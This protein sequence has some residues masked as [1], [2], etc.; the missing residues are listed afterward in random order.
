MLKQIRYQIWILL[1]GFYFIEVFIPLFLLLKTYLWIL[2][3]FNVKIKS[4]PRKYKKS[5]FELNFEACCQVSRSV[6]IIIKNERPQCSI[7]SLYIKYQAMQ[8]QFS[9]FQGTKFRL[10]IIQSWELPGAGWPGGAWC[11]SA[12]SRCSPGT[13]TGPRP[14]APLQT[15]CQ[16]ISIFSSFVNFIYLF[17][18]QQQADLRLQMLSLLLMTEDILKMFDSK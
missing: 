12:W 3:L 14:P 7:S 11:C 13:R 6:L 18:N 16:Q 8:W 2:K 1:C 15:A 5:I 9:Q 17:R 10:V 4:N